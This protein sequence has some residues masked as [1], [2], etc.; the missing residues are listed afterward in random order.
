MNW[1]GPTE[2]C[3]QERTLRSPRGAHLDERGVCTIDLLASGRKRTRKDNQFSV[4]CVQGWLREMTKEIES[5][6][7][8]NFGCSNQ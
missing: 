8:T 3:W 1:D 4:F 5:V 7:Q 2:V 6:M